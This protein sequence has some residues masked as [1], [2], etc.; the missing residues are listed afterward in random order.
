MTG[1]SIYERIRFTDPQLTRLENNVEMTVE[2]LSH[3]FIGLLI[4]IIN[5][6]VGDHPRLIA[7]KNIPTNGVKEKL[8]ETG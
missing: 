7:W 1:Q 8:V 2:K 5:P 4:D 6:V 3:Q